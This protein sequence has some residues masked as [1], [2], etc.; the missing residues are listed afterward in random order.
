MCQD[1]FGHVSFNRLRTIL[2]FKT[3]LCEQEIQVKKSKFLLIHVFSSIF[4]VCF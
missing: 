4:L 3:L 2:Y 1:K